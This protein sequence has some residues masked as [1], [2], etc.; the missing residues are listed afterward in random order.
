MSE[1]ST[2]E[3]APEFSPNVNELIGEVYPHRDLASYFLLQDVNE[4]NDTEDPNYI[5]V[6]EP[7]LD[8]VELNEE[9]LKSSTSRLG[10]FRIKH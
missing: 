3:I 10:E 8:N 7:L 5:D 6:V 2:T 1:R 9:E 4:Q